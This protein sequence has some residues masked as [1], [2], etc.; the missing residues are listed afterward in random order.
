[1]AVA[2]IVVF[3]VTLELL[4]VADVTGA[5]GPEHYVLPALSLAVGPAAALGRIVRVEALGVLS[6]D[7]LRTAR[8]KRLPARLIY[9]RH[10]LPNLLTGALIIG[11]LLVSGLVAGSVLVENVIVW[12]GLGS[13]LVEAIKAKDYPVVQGVVLVYGAA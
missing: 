12:P 4:P 9:L 2:L 8:A 6:S 7:Y 11:G 3:A 1:L 13:S 10:A 5:M